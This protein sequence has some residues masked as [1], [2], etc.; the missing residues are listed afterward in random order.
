MNTRFSLALLLL[1][2][3]ASVGFG[4][5]RGGGSGGS[6]GSGGD[7]GEDGDGSEG[8]GIEINDPTCVYDLCTCSTRRERGLIYS[9]PGLF[10]NGTLTMTHRITN[11][12][13]WGYD[14]GSPEADEDDDPPPCENDDSARKTY[15]YPALVY[16]GPRGNDSDT[17]P[18]HWTLRGY[19]PA[20][21]TMG[22][23]RPYIDIFQRWIYLRSSDF[24]IKAPT[25]E[26]SY[27]YPS[28]ATKIYRDTTVYWPTNV[29]QT[30]DKTFSARAVYNK[31]PILTQRS[32]PAFYEDPPKSLLTPEKGIDGSGN[33][34]R[35]SQY[36]TLSDVCVRSQ[37]MLGLGEAPKSLIPSGNNYRLVT[38]P[39]LWLE[40]GAE[41]TMEG[42]GADTLTFK[43][44]S[45]VTRRI[46]YVSSQ[47]ARCREGGNSVFERSDFQM[48]RSVNDP[49]SRPGE[50]DFD[51]WNLTV[52]FQ[53]SFEGT[54]ETENGAEITGVENGVPVFNVGYMPLNKYGEPQPKASASADVNPVVASIALGMIAVLCVI[55]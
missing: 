52:S 35:T 24:P 13:S 2:T 45:S 7:D 42:I 20:N 15:T 6:G 36:I 4:Q 34:P 53:I 31:E 32:T 11:N 16:I 27:Y 54:L 39:T 38:T 25:A 43:L 47:T 46:G 12:T 5:R 48:L 22:T 33:G 17:N 23:T 44:D 30:G 41:A 55:A 9:M 1:A 50:L 49:H 8:D 29:T 3:I 18:I 14:D 26:Q 51:P 28:D 19:Q 21:Q 10:Y 40:T 37:T